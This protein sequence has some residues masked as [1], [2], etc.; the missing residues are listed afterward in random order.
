M[1]WVAEVEEGGIDREFVF[2]GSHGRERVGGSTILTWDYF[3]ERLGVYIIRVRI[4]L[5]MRWAKGKDW[6]GGVLLC[7]G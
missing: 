3:L 1:E 5:V 2:A 7:L 6:A 4:G